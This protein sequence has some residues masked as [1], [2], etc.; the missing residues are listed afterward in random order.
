MCHNVIAVC[1]LA[2]AS[3]RIL[4]MLEGLCNYSYQLLYNVNCLWLACFFRIK[5]FLKVPTRGKIVNENLV[6]LK[7]CHYI[8]L[9]DSERILPMLPNEDILIL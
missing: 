9:K 7:N 8:F 4:T 3:T 2:F 6:L 5:P 1:V